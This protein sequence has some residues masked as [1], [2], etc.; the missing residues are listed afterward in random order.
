[1]NEKSFAGG[2]ELERMA[3]AIHEWAI[4]FH[5]QCLDGV[6]DG[7]LGDAEFFRGARETA[8]ASKGNE[9]EEFAAINCGFHQ[10]LEGRRKWRVL[11]NRKH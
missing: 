8:D 6:A 9:G 10:L 7:G 4:E 3:A 1:M 5:L 2:G 11:M